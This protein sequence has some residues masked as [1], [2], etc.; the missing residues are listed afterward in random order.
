MSLL[1]TKK[2]WKIKNTSGTSKT[3]KAAKKRLRAIKWRQKK[4]KARAK[5][6]EKSMRFKVEGTTNAAPTTT[7]TATTVESASEV[8]VFNNSTTAYAVAI[9]TA[10]SG[11][12]VGNVTMAGG[13][14]LIIKKEPTWAIYAANAAVMLTPVNTRV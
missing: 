10:A 12:V 8:S 9:L 2:G 3:K 14:R 1:W 13:E 5:R 11:T 6:Q 4:G 7:G